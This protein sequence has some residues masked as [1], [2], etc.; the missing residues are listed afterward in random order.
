MT[1][2][3]ADLD[4]RISEIHSM[5]QRGGSVSTVIRVGSHVDSMGRSRLR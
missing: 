2:A 5:S 3:E 1:A 4:V